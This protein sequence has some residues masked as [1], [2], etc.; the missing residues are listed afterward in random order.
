MDSS[1]PVLLASLQASLS[2][3]ADSLPDEKAVLQPPEGL[4]L[5]ATKNELF[6]SY[7]Q[8]L[9]FLILIKLRHLSSSHNSHPPRGAPSIELNAEVV[10]KL[11]E[12]RLFVEKGNGRDSNCKI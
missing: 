10:E 11:V 9:V 5:L 2:A 8:N 4:S 6:L 12:L 7:M 3:A 1:I